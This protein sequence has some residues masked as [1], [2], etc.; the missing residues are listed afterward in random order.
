MAHA[1]DNEPRFMRTVATP[2]GELRIVT[3]EHAVLEVS[4]HPD[5]AG[6]SPTP[7]GRGPVVLDQAADQLV[8]YFLGDLRAF[9]L[10]L[11]P[12]GT[13]FQQRVWN[14]LGRIPFGSTIS[15]LELAKRLGDPKCIRA[16]A[17]ANGRN[18]MAIV[19]PCHR[20][21]GSN[22]ELTGYAGGL[23]RKKYLLDWEAKLA[24]GK[25]TLF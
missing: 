24:G 11:E 15:Y 14:E 20:V 9:D 5:E 17:S 3:N 4:F 25:L 12:E 18:P 6:L 22:G 13:E 23:S 19:I 16:A 8:A 7:A 21:V 2:A 10:P 1:S